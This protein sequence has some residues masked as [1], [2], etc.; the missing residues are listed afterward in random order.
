MLRKLSVQV[1]FLLGPA[2]SGKTARCL[3]EIRT[4]LRR[5]PEGPPLLF[6][7]PKQATFQLERQLLADPNIPGYTR[8]QILSFDRLAQYVLSNLSMP[9]IADG[10]KAGEGERSEPAGLA[11]GSG[12]PLGLQP[13][14]DFGNEQQRVSTASAR[15][16]GRARHPSLL[17]E[18]GRVMVLRAIL[19][20][21]QQDL[22]VFRSVARLPGFAKELS[23]LIGELR[24]CQF[25]TR[26]LRETAG[27]VELATAR[28][29]RDL[30][31]IAADYDEW[32]RE[33]EL[34]DVDQVLDL[35]AEALRPSGVDEGG[36]AVSGQWPVAAMTGCQPQQQ[37]TKDKRR[38][39]NF[40]L[41]GLWLDGFAEMT[42]QEL[43]LLAAV[44]QHCASAT[45]AFCLEDRP[46]EDPRWLS[47]W[48]IVTRTFRSCHQR[49][50][51][52]PDTEISVEVLKRNPARGR[53][54]GNRVI[55][56][57][58]R[59]WS[60]PTSAVDPIKVPDD[61]WEIDLRKSVRLVGC[62]NPEVEAI[63]AAREIMEFVRNGGRYRE[64]AVLLRSLDEYPD[65]LRRVFRRYGIPFF[66]DRRE[67]VAHHPL[68]ELTR[69]A[70]RTVAFG[71]K[72]DDWFGALK[73]GLVL[74]EE[75]AVD[76]LEN[77]ALARGWEGETWSNPLKI[78]NDPELERFVERLRQK[79]M[80][81]F[82]VL[83]SSLAGANYRPTG[84]QL[85]EWVRE[86]WRNL[87]VEPQLRRWSGNQRPESPEAQRLSAIHT[88]VW[89]QMEEWLENLERAFPVGAQPLRDWLPILDAGLCALTV[90]V[91]PP[92]LDHVLIGAVDRSRNP[93][94]K[95]ALVLGLNESVFPVPPRQRLLL[96]DDDR[97]QIED[98]GTFIGHNSRKQLGHERYLGYVAFTRATER[99]VV[100]FSRSNSSSAQL[101]PSRFVD[102]MQRLLPGLSVDEPATADDV[103][104]VSGHPS[105][106]IAPLL[107]LQKRKPDSVALEQMKTWPSVAKFFERLDGN[108]PAAS[109]S[110]SAAQTGALYGSELRTSVSKL[111]QFAECP[112]RFFVDSGLGARERRQ[113]EADPQKLGSFQ[114]AALKRFHDELRADGKRWR[115][116]DP[117]EARLRIDAIGAD[118]MTSFGDGVMDS[119]EQTRFEARIMR[120]RLQDFVAVIVGWMRR[121]YEFSP[122]AAELRFGP[123]GDI[124]G[125][126]VEL[127]NG[128]R[129]LFTGSI[130]RVDVLAGNESSSASFVV[131][132]YKSSA[133][134]LDA[135]L[136][137]NGVQLQL[138][139]YMSVLRR[140]PEALRL[141]E[142]ED[143][144]PAGIFY[145]NLSGQYK[146]GAHRDE[147]MGSVDEA[148]RAAYKHFGRFDEE[149]LPHLDNRP[150]AED[151]KKVGDQFNFRITNRGKLE[152]RSADV[153]TSEEFEQLQERVEKLLVEMGGRIFDGDIRV[154]PY[155]YR[156]KTPCENCKYRPVCRIDP[157]THEYRAL[158]ERK[159]SPA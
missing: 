159:D 41:S 122:A 53:F 70:L 103:W 57:L 8:L 1:R 66:L 89:D 20:E 84:A 22:E 74:E 79:L 55:E 108:V 113:F 65:I 116:L 39:T 88:S 142:L 29:L 95:L 112:F 139:A 60:A 73:S 43:N 107:R 121:Q 134:K 16:H 19:A 131:V 138:P 63:Q 5:S 85:A 90:G 135:R 143:L 42:P 153:M 105:E 69:S 44:I 36:S 54:A 11:T 32:L 50:A 33:H 78:D 158:A 38:R 30:A 76:R 111:E 106:I 28:K 47:S 156:N 127:V 56:H 97:K 125:W 82:R 10:G 62:A 99:L 94:L 4:E 132:D 120:A 15:Q 123:G 124:P 140:S 145:V 81:P 58:E 17:S 157:W 34:T 6:L 104:N 46:K 26:R 148:R 118:L 40:I 114:H 137:Q 25:T 119:T 101:N 7:A 37:R 117:A 87:D 80:P 136:M 45:I 24:N 96:T 75:T 126:N 72:H 23:H 147:V 152:R 146:S 149:L 133:K 83:A 144:R 35:A 3:D 48:S 49:L 52:L 27:K 9:R 115:D 86:L 98:A 92:A 59:H 51:S 64:C 31:L 129:L 150:R 128:R 154:D 2:G 61:N 93:E 12:G 102:D 14:L 100:S 67:A 141:F 18:E 151:E 130:D 71:W 110:L 68:A 155:C 91:V 109:E 13:E 21:R 77:E